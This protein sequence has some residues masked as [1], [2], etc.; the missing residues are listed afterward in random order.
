MTCG[1]GKEC[2][3][4]FKHYQK[5]NLV[6][7]IKFKLPKFRTAYFAQ[8]IAFGDCLY[9]HLYSIKYLAMLDLNK[10]PTQ[11]EVSNWYKI[12]EYATRHRKDNYCAFQFANVFFKD[13]R[14]PF[15]IN[16]T[17]ESYQSIEKY[18]ITPLMYYNREKDVYGYNVR[19][20]HIVDTRFAGVLGV[21]VMYKCLENTK[22]FVV[23]HDI[24]MLN[25]YRIPEKI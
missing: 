2:W 16:K 5:E 21:H 25:H 19:S 3:H 12:V 18:K 14:S 13:R 7:V 17:T 10:M 22:V 15:D 20:K 24:C 6:D 11:H 9:R 1:L 8:V 4:C 23:P